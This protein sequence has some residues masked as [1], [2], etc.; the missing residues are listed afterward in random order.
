MNEII[1]VGT[2][3][4]G[5]HNVKNLFEIPVV[6][7]S[8]MINKPF[9]SDTDPMVIDC[10]TYTTG[11][12]E[13]I[14]ALSGTNKIVGLKGRI[15]Q[16]RVIKPNGIVYDFKDVIINRIFMEAGSESKSDPKQNIALEED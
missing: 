14:L 6:S 11:I 7:F 1:L 5:A 2:I 12:F 10:Q 8:I 4:Q 13:R 15:R 9:Q 3:Q 16:K